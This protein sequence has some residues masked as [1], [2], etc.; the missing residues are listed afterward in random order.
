MTFILAAID[1]GGIGTGTQAEVAAARMAKLVAAEQ[2]K[3]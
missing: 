3:P 1:C 2:W